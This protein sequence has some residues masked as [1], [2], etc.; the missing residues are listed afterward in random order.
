MV[1][2]RHPSQ[3]GPTAQTSPL[4]RRMIEDI[5]NL[6]IAQSSSTRVRGDHAKRSGVGFTNLTSFEIS[7]CASWTPY[8][9]RLTNEIVGNVHTFNDF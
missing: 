1:G 6:H 5:A 8:N 2:D 7:L 9:D 4:R 3:E